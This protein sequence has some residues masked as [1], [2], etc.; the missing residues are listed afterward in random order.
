M[1]Y[2]PK[3]TLYELTFEDPD[4]EGLEVTTRSLSVDSLTQ[5][6]DLVAR[7]QDM[8][9]NNPALLAMIGQL[10]ERFAR[11]LVSWNVEDDDDKPVP[12]TA[13][14]LQS[15]EIGFLLQIIDAW[16]SAM[17]QAPPPLPNSS[18]SGPPSPEKPTLA[19][20]AQSRSLPSS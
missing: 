9:E 3:R 4:L 12:C 18:S 13:A 8:D 11:V 10:T 7:V 19:L 16:A 5:M 17:V 20:A 15:L 2:K 1:G 6:Y 14:G